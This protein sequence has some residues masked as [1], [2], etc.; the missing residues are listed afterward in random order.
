MQVITANEL[1]SGAT[2][3]YRADGT[4]EADIDQARVFGDEESAE[5]DDIVAKASASIRLVSVATEKVSVEDG[6]VIA[7]RLRERIRAE[8][9]TTPR[10][11]PQDLEEGDHVSL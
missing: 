2:V 5:R 8:G 9:P 4:W 3:Y 7:Q 1:Q 11:T 6:R 10:H